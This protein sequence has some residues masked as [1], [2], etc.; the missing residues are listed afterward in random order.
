MTSSRRSASHRRTLSTAAIALLVFSGAA[1][2]QMIFPLELSVTPGLGYD[3]ELAYK[4]KLVRLTYSDGVGGFE[5]PLVSVYGDA[6]GPAVWTFDGSTHAARDLFVTRSIDDGRTW[7]PPVNLTGT[8]LFSS[9]L[10]DDD[11]DDLTAPVAYFG[12]NGKPNVINNGK[13]ILVTWVSRYCPSGEQGSVRYPEFGNIEVPYACTW[14]VRSNDGGVTW[15]IPQMLT[16]GFRDAK[17]DACKASPSGFGI[18]WQEDPLGLQPGD[19]EGPGDGGSGAIVSHGTDAWFTS[20]TTADFTSGLDFPEPVRLTD[21]FTHFDK[22]GFESGKT[23]A[24]RPQLFLNT[25]TAL[26]AYEETKGLEGLDDGKYIRYHTFSAF[27]DSAP[28]AT[29]GEGWILSNPDENARRVR[30]VIQ[31]SKLQS[32]SDLRLVV[33]WKQGHYDQGGPSD[34]MLRYGALNPNDPETTGFRVQDL[35]PTVDPGCT[36]RT[37]A[38]NNDPPMNLSSDQGI[39]AT[40]DTNPFEDARAHRAIVRGD[41]VAL[42]YSYTPDWAVARYTDLENYNFFVRRSFDGGATWDDARDLSQ[43]ADTTINVKEPRLV[44]TPFS[45]DPA[46]VRD[47]DRYFVAWGTEVNQYEHV[48]EESI[49]LDIFFTRT[50][51]RGDTYELVQ[52]LAYDVPGQFEAQ[53]RT[54]PAGEHLFA[55]WMEKTEMLDSI[56]VV[57]AHFRVWDGR[58]PTEWAWMAGTF[59]EVDDQLIGVPGPTDVA[60]AGTWLEIPD[61]ASVRAT[62]RLDN[63]YGDPASVFARLGSWYY[64]RDNFAMVDLWP[65]SDEI[66]FR[67]RR[68]GVIV[69]SVTSPAALDEGVLYEVEITL[70]GDRF[71][72]RLD[73]ALLIDTENVWGRIPALSKSIVQ[74]RQA[75]LTVGRLEHYQ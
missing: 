20:L 74:S 28:D 46:D 64:D 72:V 31:P 14:A 50:T 32:T 5:K 21:N 43:I 54:D 69:N 7:T 39:L 1:L 17:Q 2:G 51:D 19:A 6:Q 12:D 9:I 11:G 44:A 66:V 40:S 70:V 53:M 16:T 23:G 15:G 56:D 55:T 73:G 68:N 34:I 47:D 25:S 62:L 10:A 42:G 60:R 4:A 65:A 26:V 61:L 30:F 57:N 75:D 63:S 67:Q 35:H 38:F 49:D 48:A 41:F 3:G 45:S 27:D 36:D 18:V 37:V 24:S 29:A 59:S 8:A 52:P 22:D 71:E 58:F 13:N 33:F